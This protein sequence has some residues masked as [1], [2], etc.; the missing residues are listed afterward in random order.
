MAVGLVAL[1]AVPAATLVLLG[2][3]VAA[4]RPRGR[5]VAAG[6]ATGGLLAWWGGQGAARRLANRGDELMDLLRLGPPARGQ[7]EAAAGPAGEPA[8][9]AP[10]WRDAVV[11]ILWTVGI[12]CVFPQGLVPVAL[13]LFGVDPKVRVWFAARYAPQGLQLPVPAGFLAA[14]LLVIWRAEAIRRRPPG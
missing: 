5:R 3:P 6:V 7:D 12:L 4:A 14:G 2:R 8:A 10:R 1:A 11:G 9:K 13:N